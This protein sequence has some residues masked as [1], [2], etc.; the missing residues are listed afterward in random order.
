MKRLLLL[1]ACV[2]LP[3]G[4]GL[5]GAGL[6]LSQ[7]DLLRTALREN[8][9][10][11]AARARWEMMKQRVPQARAWDDPMTGATLD[12]TGTLR[13]GRVADTE[14]MLSQSIPVS[15]KNLSRA[16]ASEAEAL[17]AFQEF[18]RA[19]LDV[20]LRVRAAYARLAGGQG[21]LEINRRNEAF[22]GQ[23]A[24]LSRKKYEVGTATQSDVLLAETEKARLS[25][26]RAMIERDLSDQ[27][28]QLNVLAD[29]PAGSPLGPPE[30][31][32]LRPPALNAVQAEALAA[33]SRP[34]ILLAWR[35]IEAEQARL[36]LAHRQWIPDPQIQIAARQYSGAQGIREYDTGIVFSIPWANGGKY[37]AGVGEA[38]ESLAGAR[39]DYAAARAEAVGLVRDQFKKIET[40]AANYRLYHD[41]IT[42]LAQGAVDA[43]R[44]GYETDKN[45]FLE[46]I[47]A[48]R[49]LQEIESSALN[50]LTEHQVAVAELEA[51]VGVESKETLK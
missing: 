42:P 4:P 25:E 11:Q 31:P 51:L 10:L 32:R 41:R 20:V 17:A 7:D 13:P 40:A 36:Q 15:G 9:T 27:Q 37:S 34:E 19:R 14:W 48:Q 33:Q 38:R 43:T 3:L 46:L 12:R 22:L 26:T 47:T 45:S 6:A 24:D 5:F 29:R 50:Q 18:R 39:H 2:A 35:K 49:N 30:P 23:F 8:Q 1:C 21:Q 44:T 16:R 28:T